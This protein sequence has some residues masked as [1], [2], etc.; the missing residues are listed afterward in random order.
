MAINRTDAAPSSS[1]LV[2]Q[3][4]SHGIVERL[5]IDT[6]ERSAEHAI[7]FKKSERQIP[8][9]HATR[10]ILK[11]HLCEQFEQL[12]DSLH[13]GL[14]NRCK[15]FG[16][17]D[18]KPQV[19]MC[20]CLLQGRYGRH[21]ATTKLAQTLT[22]SIASLQARGIEHLDQGFDRNAFAS[23]ECHRR[24][25]ANHRRPAPQSLEK[26]LVAERIVKTVSVFV[27]PTPSI[28]DQ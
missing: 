12:R 23:P 5:A 9:L 19:V 15:C 13:G 4:R 26:L 10:V 22:S 7:A 3:A 24:S 25:L 27:V 8:L 28:I 20:K 14:A 16:C 18:S 11:V 17:F 6:F 2:L 21:A 1:V